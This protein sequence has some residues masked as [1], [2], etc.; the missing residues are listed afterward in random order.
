MGGRSQTLIAALLTV[1]VVAA[2]AVTVSVL[3]S[4]PAH[5]PP[6][7]LRPLVTGRRRR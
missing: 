2:V 6:S 5:H 3:V 7:R 4:R 1:V